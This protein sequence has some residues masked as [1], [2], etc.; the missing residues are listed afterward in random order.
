MHY[1]VERERER[2]NERKRKR[3]R[4]EEKKREREGGKERK[5]IP[6]TCL[7]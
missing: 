1:S 7:L 4:G 5:K 6:I 2:R 3:E